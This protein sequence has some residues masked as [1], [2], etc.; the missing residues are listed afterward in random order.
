MLSLG[1]ERV[2]SHLA[3]LRFDEDGMPREISLAVP[4][5]ISCR[6]DATAR[7]RSARLIPRDAMTR[8]TAPPNESRDAISCALTN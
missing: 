6:A 1:G 2:G 4:P 5:A 3:R 8:A 7:V